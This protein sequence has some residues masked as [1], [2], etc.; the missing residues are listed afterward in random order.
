MLAFAGA[1]EPGEEEAVPPN[2]PEETILPSPEELDFL[3]QPSSPDAGAAPALDPSPAAPAF[4]LPPV[5]RF[6][7]QRA[8]P[9]PVFRVDRFRFEGNTV[10]KD[11]DLLEVVASY[12]GRELTQE[13]QDRVCYLLTKFHIDHGYINS[14][15]TVPVPEPD[16][17]E[18]RIL[19]TEGRLTGIIPEGNHSLSDRYLAMRVVAGGDDPLHFPTLQRRLQVLQGNPNISRINAELKPGLVPGEATMV[20][21]MEELSRH[22]YGLDFHNQRS[23]S[24]GGEQ[25]ELW[26]ENRSITG[27]SDTLRTRLGLF[28]GEPEDLEFAGLK[29]SSASYFRPLTPDETTL[30]LAASSEDYSLLEEPFSELGIEG[31]SWSL[32]GGFRHPVF[33]SLNDE[34]WLSLMIEKS[35]DQST[36]FGRPFTISPGSVNGEL[37]LTMVRAGAEWTRR[38][39]DSVLACRSTVSFGL[40]TLGATDAPGEPDA[41]FIACAGEV[42]YTRRIPKRDDL[43]V[44]HGSCQF[45]D[46]PLPPPAQFRAGGRYTVRGYRENYLVRD[47]GVTLGAEYQWSLLDP[48]KVTDW[49]LW[50]ISFIDGGFAWNDDESEDDA[51]LSLGVGLRATHGDWFRGEIFFGVPLLDRPDNTD[52]LQD[53]GVHFRMSIAHF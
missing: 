26:Y 47:N 12:Q 22:S 33:R 8:V 42:Q 30:V 18:L 3:A 29:N 48:E 1:Q 10:F 28:S 16:Q 50:L 4:V 21:E 6:I 27:F 2:S 49:E 11:S 46:G 13:D 25:A 20:L 53:H 51:L 45:A 31:E 40:D 36:L 32:S 5:G 24:V 19:I 41:S 52:N 35:H 14:G 37:D 7:P 44:L 43:L 9:V 34:V 23:P 15:A 38:T 39:R 17:G